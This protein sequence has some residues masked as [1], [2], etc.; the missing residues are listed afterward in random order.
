MLFSKSKNE[1]TLRKDVDEILAEMEQLDIT[2]NEQFETTGAF[3]QGI[4][5]KQKEVKD[6]YEQKR[7][8]SYD[9]YKAVTTKISSYIDPLAKAERIVKKKLGDYRVEM[10]RLRRIEETEKLAIAE[11]QAETRQLAD[12]EETGDDSILDEP[13][14]VAPPVLE[15]EV[16]K[17]KGISFTTVWKFDVVN[18]DDL[19]RKYMIIDVKKIQGVVNALK[20]ASSIPGIRVFSEQQVG[21][22]A[23]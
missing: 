14:I 11:T 3:V 18:V 19:P 5:S 20:D 1:L 7:A 13:L 9:I 6:H 10:V 2:T 16:P 22:R 4:K 8:R 15:T 21:A 23:T 12:A 17:M